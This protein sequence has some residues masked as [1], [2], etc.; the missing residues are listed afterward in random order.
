MKPQR[1]EIGQAVTPLYN[2]PWTNKNG[3]I[4]N[5]PSYGE[6]Y[7]VSG[8]GPYS[9]AFHCATVILDKLPDLNIVERDLAPVI[10]THELES[11]LSEIETGVAV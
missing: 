8:Y 10:T 9:N 4:F 5:G 1:F 7:E 6:I 11:E 2:K 3:D